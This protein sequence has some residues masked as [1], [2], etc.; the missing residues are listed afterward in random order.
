MNLLQTIVNSFFAFT[1]SIFQQQALQNLAEQ[2]EAQAQVHQSTETSSQE[3]VT[4]IQQTSNPSQSSL[5][6]LQNMFHQATQSISKPFEDFWKFISG[7]WIFL[8]IFVMVILL[9]IAKIIG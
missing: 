1:P 3:N 5:Q 2:L 8:L 6:T 4:P 7:N 9:L